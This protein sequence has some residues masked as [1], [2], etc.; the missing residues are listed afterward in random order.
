MEKIQ[1][2]V[3]GYLCRRN[4]LPNSLYYIKA[5]LE[6]QNLV[7]SKATNDGRVNSTIDEDII[8]QVLKRKFCNRMKKPDKRNWYDIL[9]KDYV[10]GWIPINIKTTTTNTSDNTGNF[11]MVVYSLTNEKL[12]L[13]KTYNN[14]KMSKLLMDKLES[15][16]YNFNYK[17]DYFFLVVNKDNTKEIIINSMRGIDKPTPN[18]NNLPFQ[19]NWKYNKIYNYKNIKNCV[20]IFIECITNP[21][22][23]WKEEFF[24]RVR[25]LK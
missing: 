3:R 17:K 1:A 18:I 11:A 10:Y 9:V 6:K 2:L 5:Y 24:C 13:Q 23:S 22:P 7:I 4:R 21:K 15:K 12:N 8:I 16:E 25:N 20:D 14:G 19:I